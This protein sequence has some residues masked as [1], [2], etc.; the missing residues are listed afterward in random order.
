MTI[1]AGG[2]APIAWNLTAPPQGGQLKWTVSAKSA[3]GKAID[4]MTTVAGRR[5]RGPD[6]GLGGDAG[7]GRAEYVDPDHAARRARSPG[8]GVVDIKLDDSLAPPLEGVRAYMAAYP[9]DCF[10]QRLSRIVA[11]GDTAG[12]NQLAG[13]I[14]TYQADDGLLRYW[15]QGSLNGSEALTSY[16]LST[17]QRRRLAASRCRARPRWSRR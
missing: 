7:A 5:P 15:P 6:R 10:E 2:A 14:P 1:P 16:V 9:Y 12:W 4:K 13:E 3:D 17:D 11:L 8:C